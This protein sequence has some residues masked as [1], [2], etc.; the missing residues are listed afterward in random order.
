[1]VEQWKLFYSEAEGQDPAEPTSFTE[2]IQIFVGTR[3][4]CHEYAEKWNWIR[5]VWEMR[6]V[7][8]EKSEVEVVFFHSLRPRVDSIT[9]VQKLKKKEEK[10][11]NEFNWVYI[12]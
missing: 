1:M 8:E 7:N 9:S 2:P 10:G 11:K 6:P 5:A 12:K 4:E 3:Q